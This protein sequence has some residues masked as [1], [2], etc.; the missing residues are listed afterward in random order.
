MRLAKGP[1][2]SRGARPPV[3]VRRTLG[4]RQHQACAQDHEGEASGEEQGVLNL[5]SSR[6]DS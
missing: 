3:M 1:S 4:T 5:L 6:R 2:G